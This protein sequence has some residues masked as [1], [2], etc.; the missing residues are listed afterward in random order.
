MRVKSNG[1]KNK[2]QRACLGPSLLASRIYVRFLWSVHIRRVCWAPSSQWSPLHQGSVDGQDL[3]IPH[4]IIS[5]CWGE[6]AGQEGY[7][8]DVLV[9]FQPLGEDGP[10]ANIRGVNLNYELTRRLR[11]DEHRGKQA[12]EGRECVLGLRGPGEG[13]TS[14][15]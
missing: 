4:I 14:G 1:Q 15:R 9:L 7:W 3:P 2:A 6:V 5:L 8:V 11:K 12:L 13:S 10:D